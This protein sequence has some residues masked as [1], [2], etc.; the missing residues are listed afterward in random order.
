MPSLIDTLSGGGGGAG[1][2]NLAPEPIEGNS[3]TRYLRSVNNRVGQ[4]GESAYNTGSNFLN[5]GGGIIGQGLDTA[6]KGAQTFQQP[7]DYWSAILSGDKTAMGRA[8]GPTAT[9]VGQQ[10]DTANRAASTMLP[11]GGY[12]STIQAELPTQKAGVISQALLGLQPQAAQQ[13][14]NI[15]SQIG[16]LGLGIGQLGLGTGQLGLGEQGLG[17]Q[18]FQQLLQSLLAGR[19]QDITETGQNKALAAE[20]ANSAVKL[21]TS[22]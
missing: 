15:A 2:A 1:P 19:G 8:I 6:N 4:L 22:P 11:R 12:R 5:A 20:L 7:L 17:A 16:G 21:R 18:F 10:Y 14:G 3:L 13:V 9:A